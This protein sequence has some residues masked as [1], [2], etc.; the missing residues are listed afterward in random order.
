MFLH[1]TLQ[2]INV[3]LTTFIFTN[4]T[5]TD[6]LDELSEENSRLLSDLEIM[7]QQI[8][9]ITED[10]KKTV[11]QLRSDH[12]DELNKMKLQA[13]IDAETAVADLEAHKKQD[14]EYLQNEN[15]ELKAKHQT[16]EKELITAQQSLKHE[17][18]SRQVYTI[19]YLCD[20]LIVYNDIAS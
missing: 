9:Q 2:I 13:K 12:S 15:A 11:E 8:E 10:H 1:S 17:Q 4:Y 3:I 20:S 14:L 7:K 16:L 19:L 5:H 6:K 18:N